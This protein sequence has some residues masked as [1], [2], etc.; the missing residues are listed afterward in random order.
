MLSLNIVFFCAIHVRESFSARGIKVPHAARYCYPRLKLTCTSRGRRRRPQ[1]NEGALSAKCFSSHIHVLT[2]GRDLFRDPGRDPEIY[3]RTLSVP[4][5]STRETRR[6]AYTV[7]NLSPFFVLQ[8]HIKLRHGRHRRQHGG[9][10]L[11]GSF[12]PDTDEPERGNWGPWSTPSSCSRSCGGGV[13]H[14]TRQCLDI[15]WVIIFYRLSHLSTYPSYER[16]NRSLTRISRDTILRGMSNETPGWAS[17]HVQ[18]ERLDI[19]L[20]KF[21]VETGN[22]SLDV[23]NIANFF[24]RFLYIFIFFEGNFRAL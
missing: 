6:R 2:V 1:V 10:Y 8:H 16:W 23:K 5:R 15:E 17:W 20:V 9:G 13:A 4:I 11:P 12:V 19:A 18:G 24:S 7:I 3:L 14:Q 21:T 22:D